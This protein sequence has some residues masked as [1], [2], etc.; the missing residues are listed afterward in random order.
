M[1]HE[2]LTIKRLQKAIDE[3]VNS[4]EKK[5]ENAF[6]VVSSVCDEKT[7]VVFKE[8]LEFLFDILGELPLEIEPY[9]DDKRFINFIHDQKV[10]GT[11]AINSNSLEYYFDINKQYVAFKIKKFL[12]NESKVKFI[13]N[14]YVDGRDEGKYSSRSDEKDLP[15]ITKMIF[16]IEEIIDEQN[17][18]VEQNF[19]IKEGSRDLN[20][21]VYDK[22]AVDYGELYYISNYDAIAYDNG[23]I[24][25]HSD[26]PRGFANARKVSD[27]AKLPKAKIEY[28][29]DFLPFS[30]LSNLEV[31]A[32]Q[33]LCV[34]E[35]RG[36]KVEPLFED[37]DDYKYIFLARIN[38]EDWFENIPI[39]YIPEDI[40]NG[41]Y[42]KNH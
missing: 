6:K 38:T 32:K 7:K 17:K 27:W 20:R 23:E 31:F 10:V 28:K 3:S 2:E 36:F 33:L 9:E 15:E 40:E 39:E 5:K 12:D 19:E 35:F 21:I 4:F 30:I 22:L 11:L 42:S 1:T 37:C 13:K 14:I 41:E 18:V 25:V 29:E 16:E 34:N 24:R 8:E 26:C